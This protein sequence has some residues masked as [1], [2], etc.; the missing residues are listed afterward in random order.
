MYRKSLQSG[1][2]AFQTL[3]AKETF[4]SPQGISQHW[5]PWEAD[6]KNAALCKKYIYIY[7]FLFDLVN[8][9]KL[10]FKSSKKSL[11]QKLIY[12]TKVWNLTTKKKH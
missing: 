12:K 3:L 5:C 2:A 1:K 8:S 4:L 9:G 7:M 11:N 6:L 10:I